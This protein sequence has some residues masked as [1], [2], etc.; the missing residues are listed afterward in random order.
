MRTLN[1]RCVRD[2]NSSSIQRS[3]HARGSRGKDEEQRGAQQ[4]HETGGAAGGG[5]G[6][7]H[8]EETARKM[9]ATMRATRAAL[10]TEDARP[11]RRKAVAATKAR[12]RK[13]RGPPPALVVGGGLESEVWI[14][15]RG[16]VR[17]CI[18]VA[19]RLRPSPPNTVRLTEKGQDNNDGA[20][21]YSGGAGRRREAP[22]TAPS[23]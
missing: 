21:S 6:S 12:E 2:W 11:I 9:G 18:I 5:T 10:R 16:L 17:V 1:R 7:G 15:V 8:P 19:C 4:R 3:V 20:T 14:C 22:C 13:T 23:D